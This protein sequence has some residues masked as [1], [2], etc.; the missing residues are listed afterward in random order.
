MY[1]FLRSGW[2]GPGARFQPASRRSLHSQRL[3]LVPALPAELLLGSR[4]GLAVLGFGIVWIAKR[5]L[6]PVAITVGSEGSGRAGVAG[7]LRPTAFRFRT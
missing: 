1:Y 5:H 3:K 4:A 7:V 2:C 6:V